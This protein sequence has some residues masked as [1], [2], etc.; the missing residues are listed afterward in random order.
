MLRFEN[1]ENRWLN[2]ERLN[3]YDKLQPC[4]SPLKLLTTLSKT[5]GH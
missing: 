4:K 2:T 5:G 3:S 1:A